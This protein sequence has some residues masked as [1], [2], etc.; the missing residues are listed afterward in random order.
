MS[1]DFLL[2]ED[3]FK[4]LRDRLLKSASD[5]YKKLDALLRD[6]TDVS[7]R[8]AMLHANYEVAELANKV[9]RNEGRL[10]TSPAGALGSRGASTASLHRSRFPGA[11][12]S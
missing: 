3:K 11:R 1:A 6:R 12:P 5:F 2:K 10:G 9:G 8:Q 4:D 7:S